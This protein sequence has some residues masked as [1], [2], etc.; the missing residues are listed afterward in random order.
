[1]ITT[2]RAYKTS[3]GLTF[4]DEGRAIAR[5]FEIELTGEIQSNLPQGTSVNNPPISAVVKAI[6]KSN[7]GINNVVNKFNKKIRGYEDRRGV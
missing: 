1:M 2:I 6:I 3:D 7:G 5:E 4:E